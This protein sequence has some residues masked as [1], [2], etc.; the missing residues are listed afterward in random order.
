MPLAYSFHLRR[1][2]QNDHFRF[3]VIFVRFP[4][5]QI[6]S[7]TFHNYL[8]KAHTTLW[9]IDLRLGDFTFRHIKHIDKQNISK[10]SDM[11]LHRHNKFQW[12]FYMGLTKPNVI[13]SNWL[14][15]PYNYFKS[16]H[17]LWNSITGWYGY[18][19][20]CSGLTLIINAKLEE[21][22]PSND[23]AVTVKVQG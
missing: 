17:S 14:V 7:L 16:I 13:L 6:I 10:L 11:I 21:E 23:L 19:S 15:L 3:D 1:Q 20:L 5:S 9:H 2:E 18:N 22:L 4:R 12:D 8:L